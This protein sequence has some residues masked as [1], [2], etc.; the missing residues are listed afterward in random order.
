MLV[1]SQVLRRAQRAESLKELGILDTSMASLNSSSSNSAAL[2]YGSGLN[3]DRG[4]SGMHA[5]A[6]PAS[7]SVG[8]D[9]EEDVR[10][11]LKFEYCHIAVL[12]N[13]ADMRG[14]CVSI[15]P[16]QARFIISRTMHAVI[17]SVL[18]TGLYN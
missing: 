17:T 8:R 5:A 7:S 10:T 4:G 18:D 16:L 3:R 11:V 6:A 14:K 13:S 2:Y 1:V 12:A 9:D 15:Y